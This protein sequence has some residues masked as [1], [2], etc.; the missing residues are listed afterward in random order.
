MGRAYSQDLR[1]RVLAEVDS[2][3]GVYAAAGQRV[4]Y[5]QSFGAAAEN[6]RDARTSLGGRFQAETCRA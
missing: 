2:G 6:R 5:L 1:E 4:V 3:T